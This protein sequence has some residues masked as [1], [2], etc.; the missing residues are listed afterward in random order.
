MQQE[1]KPWMRH[2]LANWMLEVCE[3]QKC[4]QDV[5]VLAMSILDR[6]LSIQS[7]SKRHLQLLG[8]VCMFISSKLRCSSCLNAEVLVI[9]TDRSI[10]IDELLVNNILLKSQLK[11]Y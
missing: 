8:T 9:Y 4:D 6:F 3:N 5:F 11:F 1:V 10:T 7:I 2:V